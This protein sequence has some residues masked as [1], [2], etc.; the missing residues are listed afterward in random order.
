MQTPD[1]LRSPLEPRTVTDWIR[2]SCLRDVEP[3]VTFEEL[4]AVARELLGAL[5]VYEPEPLR[6]AR[7]VRLR[8]GALRYNRLGFPRYDHC[9]SALKHIGEYVA[10]ANQEHVVDAINLLVLELRYPQFEGVAQGRRPFEAHCS[11]HTT[12]FKV[13]AYLASRERAALLE[14]IVS[15]VNEWSEPCVLDAHF[16]STDEGRHT[17]EL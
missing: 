2:L 11:P 8:M 9:G 13:R 10:D 16:S 4:D 14:A 1:R 7:L 15:L 3:P 6:N 12:A 17:E 5:P